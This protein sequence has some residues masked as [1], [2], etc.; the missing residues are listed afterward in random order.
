MNNKYKNIL[1]PIDMSCKG[2]WENSL[3]IAIEQARNHQATLHVLT[4][5]PEAEIPAVAALLPAG[6]DRRLRDQGKI[7]LHDLIKEDIPADIVTEVRVNQG[8]PY[9]EILRAAKDIEADLIVMA[10][11]RPGLSDYLIGANAAHVVR[12]AKCSVMVVREPAESKHHE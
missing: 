2:S 4:V 1:I 7:A 9:K 10:S 3:P 8:Q 12:H 11:H 5:V 6:L